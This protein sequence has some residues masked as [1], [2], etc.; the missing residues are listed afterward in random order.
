MNIQLMNNSETFVKS[1]LVSVPKISYIASFQ[2]I[3]FGAATTKAEATAIAFKLSLD[4]P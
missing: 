4:V 3:A 2:K 1:L